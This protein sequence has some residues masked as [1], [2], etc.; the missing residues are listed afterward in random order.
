MD[1]RNTTKIRIWQPF[2]SQII[3]FLTNQLAYIVEFKAK[4]K[5]LK[6]EKQLKTNN[7]IKKWTMSIKY[8]PYKKPIKY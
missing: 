2:F 3:P 7:K 8:L 5:Q 6:I 1:R 4:K